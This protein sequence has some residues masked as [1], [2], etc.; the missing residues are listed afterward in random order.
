M[1][2]TFLVLLLL[3][4]AAAIG[5]Y[6]W[7][8]RPALAPIS[9][10]NHPAFEPGQ[11]VRGA[12]LAL[13]GRCAACHT[14]PEGAPYA[15]GRAA[16]TPLG[17]IYAANLTPDPQTGIGRWSEA[18]FARALGQ[19]VRRDGRQLYRVPQHDYAAALG[20][21]DVAAL[22]AFLMTRAA[23][24]RSAPGPDVA[25]PFRLRWLAFAWERMHS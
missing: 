20:D 1:R 24:H 5:V 8:W 19:G 21:A 2:T 17:A 10:E 4:A 12:Q 9:L 13:H 6:A 22:Y 7:A 16:A 23:V 15:G 25:L 11:L 14:S 18:A 3:A